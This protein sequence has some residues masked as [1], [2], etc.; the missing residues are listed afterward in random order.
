[1][2]KQALTEKWLKLFPTLQDLDESHR[3]RMLQG[4]GFKELK[5]GQIAYQQGWNCPAYV[6]CLDGQ[7]R[8][9]KSSESGREILLY[10]VGAGQTCVLTTS[11][12]LAGGT[13]P[14]ES[15][16]ESDTLLAA[17]PAAIFHE[18]MA[19]S[20]PFR[21]FVLDNYG[22]LLSSLIVLVDEVAFSSVDLRLARHLLAEVDN[23]NMV[24]KTHQQ[25]AQDLGSVRE[26]VG[27]HLG[28]WERLGWIE[29]ARGTIRLLDRE[30]LTRYSAGQ[31]KVT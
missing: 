15:V 2:D 11:C 24:H 23:E 16:A 31:L 19:E 14:A 6:M 12:L 29:I 1:M 13:F 7:T 3:A 21:R 30:A 28:E 9:F 8:I 25:I 26:V 20:L 22:D 17:L 5:A 4:I 27:R 18:L 10:R